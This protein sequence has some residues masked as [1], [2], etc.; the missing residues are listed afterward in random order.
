MK[1]TCKT[2]NKIAYKNIQNLS[3]HFAH[4]SLPTQTPT[5]Q[6][7]EEADDCKYI[8]NRGHF[9]IISREHFQRFPIIKNMTN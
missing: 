1:M 3:Y 9:K 2:K 8:D 5:T 6:N 4:N 7:L